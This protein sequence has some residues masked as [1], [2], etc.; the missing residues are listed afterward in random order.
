MK[1][2]FHD[3]FRY[4]SKRRNAGWHVRAS[5]TPQTLP[6]EV[7]DAAVAAGVAEIVPPGRGKKAKGP[8]QPGD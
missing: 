4:T 5:E 1:A 8:E 3:E 2:I 7:I 6:Q